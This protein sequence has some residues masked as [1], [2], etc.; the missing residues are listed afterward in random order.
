MKKLNW[1]TCVF[2]IAALTGGIA[3]ILKGNAV[4]GITAILTGFGLLAAKDHNIK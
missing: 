4:E 3:S 2:G 1:K